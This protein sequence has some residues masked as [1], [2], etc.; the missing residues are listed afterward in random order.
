M[1]ALTTLNNLINQ[2]FIKGDL[3]TQ[4]KPAVKAADTVKLRVLKT[5][6]VPSGIDASGRKTRL[7]F[8]EGDICPAVNKDIAGKLV[9]GGF[10]EIIK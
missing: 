10:A 7:H 4:D 5:A 3:M 2:Q 9:S 6:T 1:M 8:T